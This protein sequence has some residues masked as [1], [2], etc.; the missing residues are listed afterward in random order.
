MRKFSVLFFIILLKHSI[1]F[2]Q[3]DLDV[4][5]EKINDST[6]QAKCNIFNTSTNIIYKIMGWSDKGQVYD[7]SFNIWQNNTYTLEDSCKTLVH[8]F[9]IKKNLENY[10]YVLFGSS[11]YIEGYL[12]SN[13]LCNCINGCGYSCTTSFMRF[14][15][16]FNN[17]SDVLNT[18]SVR[19]VTQNPIDSFIGNISWGNN[20]NHGPKKTIFKTFVDSIQNVTCNSSRIFGS[21]I[22][23]GNKFDF[24]AKVQ[25]MSGNN[26]VGSELI[27]NNYNFITDAI[28]ENT[29]ITGYNIIDNKQR[30]QKIKFDTAIIIKGFAN[31]GIDKSICKNDSAQIGTN[32]VSGYSYNWLP[33]QNINNSY[34]SNPKVSPN[35]NTIYYLTVSNGL[36]IS[37]DTIQINVKPIPI[38]DAGRDTVSCFSQAIKLGTLPFPNATYFW[39]GETSGCGFGPFEEVKAQPLTGVT[40]KQCNFIVS[41]NLNGCVTRDT[42]NVKPIDYPDVIN[43]SILQNDISLC[44]SQNIIGT[45][46]SPSYIQPYL[47][48]V[49]TSPTG[50]ILSNYN[51][52]TPFANTTNTN[53]QNTH[54]FI[55]T[56]SACNWSF[57][58][59]IDVTFKPLPNVN[60]TKNINGSN[61]QLFAPSGNSSY[62]WN[63]YDGFTSSLQNTIHTYNSSGLKFVTLVS[64]LNGCRAEKTDSFNIIISK[65]NNKISF[66][67]SFKL[68]PNPTHNNINIFLKSEKLANF[69]INIYNYLGEN[70][71]YENILNSRVINK[72][73][74]VLNLDKGTYIINIESEGQIISSNFIIQ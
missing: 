18:W 35:S 52:A 34:I 63:F 62:F 37:K 74:D 9:K 54:R 48:Y 42:V 8:T 26:K 12:G 25:I 4:S 65:I 51:I 28:T 14:N 60:F 58:D 16:K 29:L 32:S 19:N 53:T 6:F 2:A 5:I 66:V 13:C 36:C 70:V 17:N 71:F 3:Q 33:V 57:K 64:Y 31:A 50:G 73:I 15:M 39:Y 46:A 49:W 7:T 67:E 40:T 10:L 61:I 41:V 59:S 27:I 30:L 11:E 24:P 68:Y 1:L 55:R 47:N 38:A 72:N 56:T 45:L 23:V 44:G 20:T 69:K 21:F 22:T 43:S